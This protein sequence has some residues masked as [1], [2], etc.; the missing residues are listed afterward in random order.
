MNQFPPLTE[1]EC[2]ILDDRRCPDCTFGELIAGPRAL[3]MINYRCDR[4]GS[5][6][7]ISTTAGSGTFGKERISEPGQLTPVQISETKKL[8]TA[9]DSVTVLV[10]DE[11]TRSD[12]G[13]STTRI[14]T[15]ASDCLRAIARQKLCTRDALVMAMTVLKIL[16]DKS[17]NPEYR[18]IV[19]KTAVGVINGW[20]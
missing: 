4:C 20:K 16:R 9:Q 10:E 6:F 11:P 1:N 14:S 3:P 12:L 5:K 13:T 2:K 18:A 17:D 7:N 15:G 19:D 8:M